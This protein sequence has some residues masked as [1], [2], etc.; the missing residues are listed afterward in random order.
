MSVLRLSAVLR[1]DILEPSSPLRS[2]S[3][4]KGFRSLLAREQSV[5]DHV[6]EN[7]K[8]KGP[9]ARLEIKRGIV[10]S[11]H[12]VL[13]PSPPIQP[14]KQRCEPSEILDDLRPVVLR[15]GSFGARETRVNGC[16]R[17]L[18]LMEA[19]LQHLIKRAFTNSLRVLPANARSFEGRV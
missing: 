19:I 7:G 16:V 2:A 4:G 17:I 8:G 6:H 10:E 18:N 14:Y 11:A 15:L 12:E 3:I 13:K 9:R 5:A 1:G